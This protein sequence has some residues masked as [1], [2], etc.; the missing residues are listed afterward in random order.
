MIPRIASRIH[1]LQNTWT[2][3]PLSCFFFFF[4]HMCVCSG[5]CVCV[6][7]CPCVL[8]P[9]F[10][11]CC[12]LGL[13]PGLTLRLLF[14]QSQLLSALQ[15]IGHAMSCQI[16]QTNGLISTMQLKKKN[17][18]AC[19]SLTY[20]NLF[21]SSVVRC[22]LADFSVVCVPL[23]LSRTPQLVVSGV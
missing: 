9:L 4:L 15:L 19:D 7:V 3:P 12:L 8:V 17:G 18:F 5:M 2:H 6:F 20:K 11:P 22:I 10:L 14:F 21:C 13:R 23:Y 1:S 16:K